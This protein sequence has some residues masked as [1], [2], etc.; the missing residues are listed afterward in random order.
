MPDT[1]M[2]TE[3]VNGVIAAIKTAFPSIDVFD[4]PVEQGIVEPSFTVRCIR[5]TQDQFLGRRYK[6]SHLIEIVYF[7]LRGETFTNLNA[8]A[9]S[10]FDALEVIQAGNDPVR[11]WNMDAHYSE[12][13][14]ALIMTVNY[15][16][17]VIRANNADLMD[18]LHIEWKG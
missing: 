16:Y 17:F 15:N 10:L 12:D 13:N 6:K 3:V 1:D 9:E 4:N 18:S 5:P 2:T 8:V 7:P 14:D 11:G